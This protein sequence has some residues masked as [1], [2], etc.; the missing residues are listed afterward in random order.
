LTDQPTPEDEKKP[1]PAVPDAQNSGFGAEEALLE[2]IRRQ[3]TR[4]AA[5]SPPPDSD[6][7][8][9]PSAARP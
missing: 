3:R 2:M 4:P 5:P 7:A 1:E 6:A 9:D 8:P